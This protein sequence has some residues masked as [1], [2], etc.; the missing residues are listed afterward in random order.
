MEENSDSSSQP[1]GSLIFSFSFVTFGLLQA[2]QNSEKG[3]S[4]SLM[5][6]STTRQ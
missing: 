3:H 4:M 5:G 1:K 6:S 2:K